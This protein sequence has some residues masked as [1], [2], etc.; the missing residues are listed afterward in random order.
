[1]DQNLI[2]KN[3]NQE[4]NPLYAQ[5]IDFSN[6]NATFNSAQN[7]PIPE[8]PYYSSQSTNNA[9]LYPSQP[10]PI[11]PYPLQNM[12]SPQNQYYPPQGGNPIQSGEQ[13]N[14]YP[15]EPGALMVQPNP[16]NQNI[17]SYDSIQHKGI[18][19]T[20]PDTFYITKDYGKKCHPCFLLFLGI[21]N[22]IFSIGSNSR[23]FSN[24]VIGLSLGLFFTIIGLMLSCSSEENA[25]VILYS[26]SISI[27]K[28]KTCYQKQFLYNLEDLERIDFIYEREG[29]KKNIYSFNVVRKNGEIDNILKFIT[30]TR[31]LFTPEEIE[32]FLYKVNNHIHS[33]IRV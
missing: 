31:I 5:N 23:D 22:I 15:L 32:Y 9:Q 12:S 14:Y 11:Q 26:N 18:I 13:I 28:R 17:K 24:S 10:S 7:I 30:Y 8:G 21:L 20:K 6:S 1:M 3:Q 4:Q 33:K 2:D 27:T 16:P 25:S 29:N 19:Q